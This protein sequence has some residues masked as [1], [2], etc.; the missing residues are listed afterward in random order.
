MSNNVLA[1]DLQFKS[2]WLLIAWL[3][4]AFNLILSVIPVPLTI[5]INQLDKAL[6]VMMYV[7]PASLF[8]GAYLNRPVARTILGLLV[9]SSFIEAIQYWL[10]WRSGEWLDLLANLVGISIGIAIASRARRFMRWLE[11]YLHDA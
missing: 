1:D 7:V 5:P 3:S 10:P 4:L 2:Y 11:A 9:F 6:H 8:G